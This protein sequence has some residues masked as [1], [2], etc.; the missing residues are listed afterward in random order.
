VLR[1]IEKRVELRMGVEA[2]SAATYPS[3]RVI[4]R[5]TGRISN[6]ELD[7][8]MGSFASVAI[9]VSC[10]RHGR[11]ANIIIGRDTGKLMLSP[12]EGKP[13]EAWKRDCLPEEEVLKGKVKDLARGL[14]AGVAAGEECVVV[15]EKTTEQTYRHR[16]MLY[17]VEARTRKEEL[18]VW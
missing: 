6:A 2:S 16:G 7:R 15:R 1:R 13:H 10:W 9:K 8:V 18:K 17:E 5:G 14:V 11:E 3:G 12:S 4:V